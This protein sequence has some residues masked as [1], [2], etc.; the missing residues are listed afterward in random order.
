MNIVEHVPLWYDE[1]SFG[2][3]PKSGIAGSSDRSIS[4]FLMNLQIDFLSDCTSLQSNQ[5]WMS[6]PLSPHP[7]QPGLSPVFVVAV[8]VVVVLFFVFCFILVILVG[9]RWNLRVVL[10]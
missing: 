1:A 5:Q 3:L 4:N 10:I 2:Y 7:L 6:V 9:I 8:V